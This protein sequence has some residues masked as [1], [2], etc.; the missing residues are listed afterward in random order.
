MF[1]AER[2]KFQSKDPDDQTVGESL[3]LL[4]CVLEHPT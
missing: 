4:C 1:Q 2:P 3:S